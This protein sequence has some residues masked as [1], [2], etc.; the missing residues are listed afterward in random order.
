MGY[1]ISL[2]NEKGGV[3]KSSL[4]FSTAWHLAAQGKK[5]LMIDMDGQTA[6]LTYIAGIEKRDG[7]PSM[8]D[9][10]V[11]GSDIA[12]CVLPVNGRDG[13]FIVPADTAMADAM[14]TVKLSRMK[15]VIQ[16]VRQAY[17]YIFVDVSPSPDWK[18]ALTL[19]TADY[20]CI[21]MLP[22][23]M[24]LEANTGIVES[25]LDVKDGINPSLKVA[26]I[27][28]NQFDGRTNLGKAVK[29]QADSMAQ[30]L[31]TH[32]FG[33]MIRKTVKMPESVYYHAGITQYEPRSE[34]SADIAAFTEE[35]VSAVE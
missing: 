18:H 16:S 8:Y 34:I 9:C 21:V 11:R 17:D 28:M 12:S 5:V 13:L 1:G 24:S 22:D 2:I 35:L 7:M 14:T 20:V 32:L 4:T 3:G 15:K 19:G 27:V 31:D 29:M 26:G 30:A 33:T 23:V 6:N 25:I 10:L